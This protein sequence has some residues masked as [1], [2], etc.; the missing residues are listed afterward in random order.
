[1]P[2]ITGHYIVRPTFR[3]AGKIDVIRR[4]S[5]KNLQ[6]LFPAHYISVQGDPLYQLIYLLFTDPASDLGVV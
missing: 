1:M 3:R 4:I 2:Y 5:L 6:N